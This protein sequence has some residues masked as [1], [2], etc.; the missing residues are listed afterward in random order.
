MS[1]SGKIKKLKLN[2]PAATS[3][4]GTPQGSRAGSP[5]PIGSKGLTASRASS[6]ESLRGKISLDIHV[7]T[8]AELTCAFRAKSHFYTGTFRG[9][10]LPNSSRD[11]CRHTSNWYTK[12]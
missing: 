12:Q 4:G 3:Q 1:E 7:F 11:S 5:I 9:S 2:P 10:K 6:P 8:A